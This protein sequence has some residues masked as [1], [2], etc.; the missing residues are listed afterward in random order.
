[1]AE[2]Q[3][4]K[5]VISGQRRDLAAALTRIGLSV[6]EPVYWGA[7]AA[8]NYVYDHR[9]LAV[10]RA[11]LPVISVGNLTTG[12]TGKS[13]F[14]MWLARHFRD[15]G[16]RVCVLS[17]GYKATA[18]G[19]NDESMELASRLPDVAQILNRDRV[20]G[21]KKAHHEKQAQVLVLDDGFQHRRLHRDLD[22]V[23]IDAAQP[24]G[25]D[26]L[27]PRGL[28]REP[29]RSLARADF[30]VIT[31]AYAIVPDRLELLRAEIRRHYKGETIG[32]S[33]MVPNHLLQS[34]G[35]TIPLDELS[36]VPVASFCGVGNPAAFSQT[37]HDLFPN[38]VQ[39]ASFSDHH[40][41]SETEL[42]ALAASAKQA[43]ARVLICTHK[44]LVKI[45]RTEIHDIPVYA[46]IVDLEFLSGQRELES[47]LNKAC[48]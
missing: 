32:V 20:A 3:F 48:G 26:R 6:V 46:L 40:H 24:F 23:L 28:L 5:E 31:R 8:R 19:V 22:I 7:V 47:A 14:V 4:L 44:D 27:L 2:R 16:R 37:V 13:P 34:D 39:H 29:K 18:L 21:A 9:W 15:R 17:R 11:G 41:Y 38:V 43:G 30:V 12:G 36:S 35:T 33:R 10:H 42:T 25:F 1:M 45:Q